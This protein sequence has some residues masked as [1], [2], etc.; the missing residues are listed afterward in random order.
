[1]HKMLEDLLF[2]LCIGADHNH[3]TIV[4]ISMTK[5]ADWSIKVRLRY[6]PAHALLS[7]ARLNTAQ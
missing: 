6:H 3:S 4:E 2:H 1:M 7:E 5:R